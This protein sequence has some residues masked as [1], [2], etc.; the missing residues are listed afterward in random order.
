MPD[1][2]LSNTR[3]KTLWP[4]PSAYDIRDAKAQGGSAFACCPPVPSTASF[5]A[6]RLD[7]DGNGCVHTGPRETAQG[8]G[9]TTPLLEGH[10]Q[11][12]G[13]RCLSWARPELRERQVGI[14]WRPPGR[15]DE[16][17]IEIIRNATEYR[18]HAWMAQG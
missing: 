15:S 10:C 12:R 17:V 7:S 18:G 5:T 4:R 9:R 2:V 6:I 8:A 16:I 3:V 11:A 13:A 1:I 14:C